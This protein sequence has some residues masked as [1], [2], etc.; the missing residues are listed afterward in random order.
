[1]GIQKTE[2][3]NIFEYRDYRLFLKDWYAL[4]KK[5]KA[6]FSFRAFAKKAGF[7]TSNFLMLV[8]NGKRNL[9]EQ[10]LAKFIIGMDLNKQE[11]EFFRSLVFFNQSKSHEEKNQYYQQLLQSK[12]FGQLMPIEKKQYEYY[13]SWYHPVIRE[14]VCAKDFDGTPEWLSKRLYPTIKASQ[15]AKSISL[16]SDLGFIEKDSNGK[17]QQTSSIV[18]TGP[19]LTSVVVHNYH[20][21]I[22]DLTKAVMDKLTVKKRDVSTMTLGVKKERIPE[23]R[24]K[25]REFRQEI[26]K[27]VS[28]DTEP[29]QV[30]Q[31]NLQLFNVTREKED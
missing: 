27:M 22:L 11:T 21:V 8:M 18:S 20:K 13:S 31:L 2:K 26:L 4:T 29:E 15:C 23:L 12:K 25:L 3:I 28:N 14:L 30:V 24:K 9:T 6:S 17:W 1:M 10:S 19:E 7:K 16:L 5:T